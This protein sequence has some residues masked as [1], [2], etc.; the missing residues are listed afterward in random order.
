M[1]NRIFSMYEIVKSAS[2]PD[3]IRRERPYS[4]IL[5]PLL[6]NE[7]ELKN[8]LLD[9]KDNIS[10]IMKAVIAFQDMNS[11]GQYIMKNEFLDRFF[12]EY[13]FIKNNGLIPTQIA[14]I[15]DRLRTFRED[16]LYEKML[17][18]CCEK[19]ELTVQEAREL[20][21]R[22][23]TELQYFVSYEYEDNTELNDQRINS[24]YN[25]ANT[26][27]MLM[28]SNGVRLETMLNDFLNV[29]AALPDK[30]RRKPLK[31][32]AQCSCV[33]HQSYVGHASFRKYKRV[34]NEE[35]YTGLSV[36]TLTDEEK[37]ARTANLFASAPNRYSVDRV[38]DYLE[39]AS[40]R[41]MRSDWKSRRWKPER[42]RLCM[43]QPCCIP[44]M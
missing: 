30:R 22:Y 37:E 41:R 3:S 13:F 2:E 32:A 10:D 29:T 34:K 28:A 44:R 31:K 42:K 9:L 14:Y 21:D 16:E 38:S 40:A 1:S 12:S 39:D 24:Y 8:E 19:Q 36:S 26:R 43:R 20:L 4:N 18:E 15:R 11:L 33:I 27:I 25:L 5:M 7:S 17:V 6:D 23:F 35:Q